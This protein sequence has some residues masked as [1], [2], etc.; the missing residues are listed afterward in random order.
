MSIDK[1]HSFRLITTRRYY[2]GP[3]AIEILI[4]GVSAGNRGFSLVID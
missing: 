2:A 3:H 1:S 4:N